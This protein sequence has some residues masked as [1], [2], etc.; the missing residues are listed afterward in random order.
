MFLIYVRKGKYLKVASRFQ[1]NPSSLPQLEQE[2]NRPLTRKT[3]R[4]SN[5][6]PLFAAADLIESE[7]AS[8]ANSIRVATV[9]R[10]GP[11]KLGTVH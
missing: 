3:P 9:S 5:R 1:M 2:E 10:K 6:I 8:V 4:E 11:A 7:L